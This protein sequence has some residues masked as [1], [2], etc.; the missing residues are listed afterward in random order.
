MGAGRTEIIN[1]ALL[2]MG[3]DAILDP[4]GESKNAKL[5]ASV[6]DSTLA[7]VL[8][9]HVWHFAMMA[10]QLQRLEGRPRDIRFRYAYQLP[11]NFGRIVSVTS[12]ELLGW[13]E[14]TET[15]RANTR[16]AAE[17]MVQGDKLVSNQG[18]LQ[19]LF[20]RMDVA[21]SEMSPQF[22]NYLAV[23]IAEKLVVKIT[24]SV[25]A[26]QAL[27]KMIPAIRLE[28]FHVDNEQADTMPENRPNLFASARLY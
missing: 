15:A 12:S 27:Q 16:P 26:G 6:F 17:Y 18:S 28:A 4:A 3:Q 21:P 5:C 2:F 23:K 13:G 7:E 1:Q 19:I 14:G 20:V 24:G 22:R 25:Q 11:S 8:C 10:A 9:G